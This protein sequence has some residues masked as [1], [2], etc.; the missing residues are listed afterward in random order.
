MSMKKVL[1]LVTLLF[2]V[3]S[4]KPSGN[5]PEPEVLPAV[6]S[7][8]SFTATPSTIPASGGMGTVEG[9]KTDLNAK[10]AKVKE[11]PV[12]KEDFTLSL[13]SGDET[14]ITI[15]NETKQFTIVEGYKEMSFVL[16]AA[17]KVGER[18]STVDVT[19][20][21]EAGVDPVTLLKVPLEYVAEYNINQAG[22]Q[23][24]TKHAADNSGYFDFNQAVEK[25][26]A[27]NISGED[28]HLPTSE[29]WCAIIP[30]N[31]KDYDFYP[32]FKGKNKQYINAVE[33]VVIQ[34]IAIE[35]KSDYDMSKKGVSYGLRF[36]WSRL[37][38]A[39]RYQYVK[40]DDIYMLKITARPLANET[41]ASL[42]KIADPAF[43]ETNNAKDI[44][45]FIPAG[46]YKMSA[47]KPVMYAG[48]D[49]S[50]W[51]ATRKKAAEGNPEL[52]AFGVYFWYQDVHCYDLA[53]KTFYR[54][55][56]LFKGK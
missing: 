21:R 52:N 1:S 54:N 34:G 31:Q 10:G 43:W 41:G 56:R 25:F 28:Y 8:Y 24:V 22:D 7:T 33:P 35:A 6:K 20:K 30:H 48:E 19:V 14:Q 51:T 9:L 17:I 13:K 2:L 47:D 26:K 18:T 46:G 16:A 5:N 27:I 15:D 49:G 32:R 45:R 40:V 36:K 4:C 39:W 44:V 12:A 11:T 42:N 55:V 37:V 3:V 23:F 29:E 38:S 53:P 50:F